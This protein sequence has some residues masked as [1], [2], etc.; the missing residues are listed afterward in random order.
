M[1]FNKE[2]EK[3]LTQER[4]KELLS[5]DHETGDFTWRE[6]ISRTARVGFVAGSVSI[7]KG[8]SYIRIGIAE[9]KWLAHRLAFL[10]ITGSFPVDQVDHIDGNGL[11][12]KWDNIREASKTENGRNQRLH[13]NNTSGTSGVCWMKRT[14]KWM[15]QIRLG[16]LRK[17]L[18]CFTN[19]DDAIAAKK[20]AE[21]ANNFHENHG[22]E[23]PL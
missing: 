13:R 15:A 14:G 2:R 17:Y 21:I 5:Y 23:R 7:V 12:N 4:L 8:K 11:N 10:Y 1:K 9:R 6:N 18:G 19:K 20:A 22:Q 16:K 3:L